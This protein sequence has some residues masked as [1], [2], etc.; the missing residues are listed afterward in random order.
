MEPGVVRDA[1]RLA[2]MAGGNTLGGLLLRFRESEQPQWARRIA[3]ILISK[4]VNKYRLGRSLATR[5][6]V[7][8]LE[9]FRN[10]HCVAC[11]G[12]RVMLL[13][14]VKITCGAC[15]GTGKQ[16]FDDASRRARIGAYGPRIDAAMTSAH[17]WMSGALATCMSRASGRL[18]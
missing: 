18:A 11:N 12:A 5:V 9:E 10:P 7:A 16:R 2:A 14:K 1:D 13:E 4:I 3:L 17:E 15:D 8:A 6:A